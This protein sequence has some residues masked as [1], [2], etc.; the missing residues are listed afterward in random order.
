MNFELLGNPVNPQ[1]LTHYF[2][3][4]SMILASI[5]FMMMVAK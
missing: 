3:H 5:N 2:T 4:L 1:Y